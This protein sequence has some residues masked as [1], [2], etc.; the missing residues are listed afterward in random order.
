MLPIKQMITKIREDQL[1]LLS[2]Q[3]AYTLILALFPFFIVLVILLSTLQIDTGT[4]TTILQDILPPEALTLINDVLAQT[5]NNT[6]GLISQL[7]FIALL[8]MATGLIPLLHAL[9]RL[10]GISE[11]RSY[12]RQYLTSFIST[13]L[14][15]S[16]IVLTLVFF[17]IDNYLWAV[18]VQILPFVS[19]YEA[20]FNTLQI[21]VPFSLFILSLTI[22]YHILP[23]QHFGW[24]HD[25]IAACFSTLFWIIISLAFSFY[26]T[27]ISQ[28]YSQLYGGLAAAIALITWLYFTAYSFLLG[29]ECALALDEHT[30]LQTN[31]FLRFI[32]QLQTFATQLWQRISKKIR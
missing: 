13:L 25:F 21:I 26:V 24:R 10:Y 6:S 5:T 22:I 29:I 17:V 30:P 27:N 2:A 1:G 28:K 32:D 16:V 31:R 9:N 15:M 14:I 7:T 4:V 20:V 8:S 3:V 11:T 23:N 18:I 19:D 12:P